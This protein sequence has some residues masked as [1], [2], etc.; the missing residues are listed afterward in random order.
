M[1]GKNLQIL[2]HLLIIGR[3]N[4]GSADNTDACINVCL[5]GVYFQQHGESVHKQLLLCVL[6][7]S[8]PKQS[9]EGLT[10]KYTLFSAECEIIVDV[11]MSADTDVKCYGAT[12]DVKNWITGPLIV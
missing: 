8:H 2:N 1:G 11:P 4:I 7:I 9:P 5:L 12:K 3:Y 6:Q 10:T